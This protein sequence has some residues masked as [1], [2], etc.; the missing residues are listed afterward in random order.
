MPSNELCSPKDLEL[1]SSPAETKKKTFGSWRLKKSKRKTLDHISTFPPSPGLSDKSSR[2]YESPDSKDV[3]AYSTFASSQEETEG[4]S[5]LPLPLEENMD[6]L[7]ASVTQTHESRA[8]PAESPKKDSTKKPVLGKIGNLFNS[9]RKSKSKSISDSPTSPTNEKTGTTT[10]TTEHKRS[11]GTAGTKEQNQENTASPSE[12]VLGNIS[13]QFSEDGDSQCVSPSGNEVNN[14]NFDNGLSNLQQVSENN[15]TG[16][17]SKAYVSSTGSPVN[18][19]LDKS[20]SPLAR[21]EKQSSGRTFSNLAVRRQSSSDS[22]STKNS[23]RKHQSFL[24]ESSVNKEESP[25]AQPKKNTKF[26]SR[27]TDSKPEKL[28]PAV[29]SEA[30]G[31]AKLSLGTASKNNVRDGERLQP[32]EA[33]DDRNCLNETVNI[34]AAASYQASSEQENYPISQTENLNGHSESNCGSKALSFDIY[35]AKNTETSSP[36]QLLNFSSGETMEKSPNC[37]KANRKKRSLKSQSSQNDEK[38]IENTMPDEQNTDL[39]FSFEAVTENVTISESKGKPLPLSPDTTGPLSANQDVRAGANRKLSPKGESDK[40]KQ[41]HPASSPMRKKKEKENQSGSIPAS[42]TARKAQGSLFKNQPGTLAKAAEGNYSVLV[43]TTKAAYVEKASVPGSSAGS[44]GEDCMTVSCESAGAFTSQTAGTEDRRTLTDEEQSPLPLGST[45]LSPSDFSIINLKASTDISKPTIT[46]K[47]NIAP[48]PKNVELPI[49]SKLAGSTESLKDPTTGQAI[50]RGNTA[51]KISLFENKKTS[52][53]QI[54]FYATKSISQPKKYVERAKLNF[55]KKDSISANKQITELRSPDANKIEDIPKETKAK[56]GADR[57]D[58]GNNK[59]DNKGKSENHLLDQMLKDESKNDL[60]TSK[61]SEASETECDGQ[62]KYISEVGLISINAEEDTLSALPLDCS[63]HFNENTAQLPNKANLDSGLEEKYNTGMGNFNTNT[64]A[65]ANLEETEQKSSPFLENYSTPLLSE[66]EIVFSELSAP[67]TEEVQEND[68]EEGKGVSKV[69]PPANSVQVNKKSTHLSENRKKSQE[70]E[71]VIIVNSQNNVQNCTEQSNSQKHNELADKKDIFKQ[72]NQ[73]TDDSKDSKLQP[74]S[75]DV[76]VSHQESFLNAELLDKTSHKQANIQTPVTENSLLGQDTVAD[77]L[78]Q[79][80]DENQ[81]ISVVSETNNEILQTNNMPQDEHLSADLQK[82]ANI[83]VL[84]IDGKSYEAISGDNVSQTVFTTGTLRKPQEQNAST[85]VE[86]YV[87]VLHSETV[88]KIYK[89]NSAIENNSQ[90]S[91]ASHMAHSVQEGNLS[92]DSHEESLLSVVHPQ[93]TD[94]IYENNSEKFVTGNGRHINNILDTSHTQHEENESAVLQKETNAQILDPKLPETVCED[95][96]TVCGDNTIQI[97]STIDTAHTAQV[98]NLSTVLQKE[99]NFPVLH[100]LVTEEIHENVSHKSTVLNNDKYTSK[101]QETPHAPQEDNQSTVLQKEMNG[102]NLRPETTMESLPKLV[103][104]EGDVCIHNGLDVTKEQEDI[105]HEVTVFS[106]KDDDVV[107]EH[108]AFVHDN[109]LS[110]NVANAEDARNQSS[111]DSEKVDVLTALH[112]ANEKSVCE[113]TVDDSVSIYSQNGCVGGTESLSN[114]VLKYAVDSEEQFKKLQKSPERIVSCSVTSDDS[115][116]DSSSDME[117][118]A[119]TIRKLESP[120]TMPQKRK[121]A[122]TPKPPS[123]YYG[124]PPIHE[125]F[126][127]KILDSETFSFGLGR[128][129]KSNN[130]APLALF[131]LQSKETAEKLKPKRAST[132]Q[133]LLLKSLRPT[134]ETPKPQ[135]TCDKENADVT[136]FEVKRSRIDSMYAGSK[137]TSV[138]RSE[139]NIFS[140]TVTTVSSITT[141]FVTDKKDSSENSTY[142]RTVDSLQ[143]VQ[144]SEKESE[145]NNETNKSLGLASEDKLHT[146]FSLL[147]FSDIMENNLQTSAASQLSYHTEVQLPAAINPSSSIVNVFP[148]APPDNTLKSNPLNSDSSAKN[149]SDIF[150]FNGVALDPILPNTGSMAFS[151][152]GVEKIN[153]RPGK[154]VIFSEANCEGTVYEIFT[155]VADCSSWELSPTI[156]IKTIRGCWILYEHPNFEGRSIALEEGDLELTN[157]WGEEPQ[158]EDNLP[159]TVIGSLRLVV[160]DYRVCQIDLFTEPDGLGIMA[161]YLDDT[162]ELQVYG[163]LQK[164]CSIKVH[165]G[166]WLVYEEPGFQGIPFIIEPGEYP[167]LSFWNTMEAYI[168]SLRPLKMGC[169]KVEIPYEPKIIIYEKPLFEGRQVEL[170]K[171]VL[172]LKDLE[173]EEAIKKQEL[174]PFTIVGSLRVISGLWVGY[175][176]PGFEGHQ[177]LLEEGDYEEWSQWGGFDGLLQSLRPIVSDFSAPHMTMYSEKDLDEKAPNINVLGIIS[178]MDETGYGEKTQSIHVRSGVWVAYETP[179]FTG[180]QYVL[181]KGMYSHFGAWGAKDFKISSVQ[182]LVMD[183]VE[184]SRGGFKVQLFSEPDFKGSTHI[185]EGDANSIED[186]FTTK[187]CKVFSGRWVAYDKEDFSGNLWVLEEGNYPSLCAIGCQQETAIRSLQTINY[188]FSEPS[189]VLYGKQNFQ[190]R[191]VKLSTVTTNL[192]AMGY[193]PDLLSA[194]VLGG[195]WVL[196]EYSNYRGRQ[197]ILSPSKIADWRTFSEWNMIGSLRPLQQKRLYFKL[198]NKDSGM[199]LSTNGN[200]SDVKLLRIQ[201][202]EDTGAEDQIW[203]YHEGVIRCRI[204]EDCTFATTGS[205]INAGSKLGLT[206]EETGASMHWNI[207]SDGRIYTSSKPNL[208][209]DIKGGNQYDQQHVVLNPFTEGKLTQLWEVCIL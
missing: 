103:K 100:P 142:F 44:S 108:I 96:I 6:H 128:K 131:K 56:K 78:C 189:I 1:P 111:A 182:P 52:Q 159:P 102:V 130:L 118:F 76:H 10:R 209:L 133:S 92:I 188:E 115:I 163:K 70:T 165:W 170:E 171:E 41:Q 198:Q 195:I 156:G 42:P 23:C 157:P 193:S 168:G 47:L 19:S 13:C 114:A 37:R 72:T 94:N 28:V 49:K 32:H 109:Q 86:K 81:N 58:Y 146:D 71:T 24:Q 203:V 99:T 40:G 61:L 15:P 68:N 91:C 62:L 87:S 9:T 34:V 129:E 136:D 196:Y 64:K 135:E 107:Y 176:K 138:S 113:K 18:A 29:D 134:R 50:H 89:D 125:D 7:Q 36:T 126:L 181:E 143:T 180:E 191:K 35:L 88:K 83:P 147:S 73:N 17:K 169:R 184:N 149:V 11:S 48:K 119:E 177:Y 190:G 74:S 46:T 172:K 69:I 2:S 166:V 101:T 183:A 82:E 33:S 202:M 145:W 4:T 117:Q 151:G 53:K 206:L 60:V 38:Q 150:Y 132:E 139:E 67:Q 179:D 31:A 98:E 152:K 93:S 164:T 110:Q 54:D 197:I 55:G 178:N 66:N 205:L 8:Q 14:G 160:K 204:A 51:T 20:K 207:S 192:Q 199:F 208:V 59:L 84:E 39:A 105:T 65:Q 201:V 85:D 167:N 112:A 25:R 116:L 97:N 21:P 154:I 121:K 16:L 104:N 173:T 63:V 187:S 30:P 174:A 77:G 27:P 95:G 26:S 120:I 161:S 148:K 43:S 123:P 185:F 12:A 3:Q 155:D 75:N 127:E 57:P 158:S 144:A 106:L 79:E 175:E 22:D 140:P 153:P 194:E 122:R 137:S 90:T 141:S 5:E 200:L 186:S 80:Q 162:E 45:T 124:L